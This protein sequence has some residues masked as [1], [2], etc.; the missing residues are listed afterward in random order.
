VDLGDERLDARVAV[1]LTSLGSRPNLSIPAA[2]GGRAETQAAYRFFD[3]PK[4]TFEK[5]LAPHARRTRERVGA[6]DVALLVQDTT[7]VDLTRPGSEVGGVGELD[8][9]RRGV[10]LHVMHAFAPDGTP[11][12]TAWARVLNRVGGVS[13][14]PAADKRRRR[15]GRP[16]EDKESGRWL[17]GLRRARDLAGEVPRTRCVC[18]ADSEA[19]VYGLFAE[20]RSAAGPGGA[21]VGL[22]VRAGHDRALEACGQG[23]GGEAGGRLR[24]RVM[25]TPVLYEVELL[26]RGRAAK[27][28]VEDRARRQAR[29]TRRATVQVRAATVT[30]RP[31]WRG[32]GRRLPPVAVNAVMVREPNPPAGEPAVEW[33]LVTTLPV[34][35]P[36][37]VR[38]VVEYYCVRWHV[39]VLF[40]TLKSGCRV[41]RRRFEHA[42]R[43]LPCLG[44]Y[45]IVAWRT[46]FVCRMGRACPDADCEVLFEPSEW[47]AVWAAVRGERPPRKKPRLAEVVHLVARLGGHVERPGSEPGAQT[48]WVGLQRMYDLAW[49]WESFGPGSR[50]GP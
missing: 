37:R 41:E 44:L 39:E 36:D 2:C 24:E 10:L 27:T 14:A 43:V 9:A 15:R 16:I 17:E 3:N 22:L 1:L 42:D 12:G 48:M 26:V 20:E 5:V 4:V 7:E 23:G 35:T 31:P 40:R 38:A 13:H 46:L 47:K 50:A 21:A 34:D 18:V 8:G 25:A 19:D 33:V 11:L 29:R 45:L 32:E 49:A 30:L 28:G 6:Q